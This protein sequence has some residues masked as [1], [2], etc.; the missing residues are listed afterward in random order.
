MFLTIYVYRYITYSDLDVS[1]LKDHILLL[2]IRVYQ[3]FYVNH[4]QSYCERTFFV[5]LQ[6]TLLLRVIRWNDLYVM[7][8]PMFGCLSSSIETQL[9]C[10]YYS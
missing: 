9:V 10:K 4:T 5:D 6:T 8:I 3:F 2:N 1:K 7:V